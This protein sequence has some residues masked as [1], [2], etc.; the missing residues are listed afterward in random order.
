MRMRP[1]AG[2]RAIVRRRLAGAGVAATVAL[3]VVIA[4]GP[5]YA[6]QNASGSIF[7]SPSDVPAGGTVHI[8]GSVDPQG[9]PPSTPAIPVSTGDLFPG[10]FGPAMTRNSQGA[11]ALDYTVPT[12]TP[13]GTYQIGLRC[14]GGNVGVFASLQVDPSGGPATGAGGTAHRSSLPWT[15]L[16]AGCLLLAGAVVAVRRRLARSPDPDHGWDASR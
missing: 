5:A 3:L 10:S 7:V 4:G 14:G 1:D 12:S 9:C 13:A 2:R 11:F 15:V 8:T 16:G 6:G